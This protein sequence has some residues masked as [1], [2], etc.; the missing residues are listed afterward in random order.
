MAVGVAARI[1]IAL[2]SKVRVIRLPPGP[3]RK[4]R[5]RPP[6]GSFEWKSL[7]ESESDEDLTIA[8]AEWAGTLAE[9][10]TYTDTFELRKAQVVI[11]RGSGATV[12]EDVAVW[13]FHFIKLSA[14]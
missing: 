11:E 8:A 1:I 2:G 7:L 9:V 6:P 12:P 13:T 10:A 5:D 4:W 3:S 14:G